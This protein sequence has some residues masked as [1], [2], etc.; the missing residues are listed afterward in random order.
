MVTVT[1]SWSNYTRCKIIYM[2]ILNF[3]LYKC[4]VKH[5]NTSLLIIFMHL[6][7][8]YNKLIVLM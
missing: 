7:M 6:F 1:I 3:E 5:I 8:S 2:Y 4:I